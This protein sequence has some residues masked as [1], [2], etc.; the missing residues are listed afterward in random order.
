MRTSISGT[1]SRISSIS[2]NSLV[3][4]RLAR[5]LTGVRSKKWQEMAD[6]RAV[7]AAAT[8][9]RSSQEV[10]TPTPA[11]ASS[12]QGKEEAKASTKEE[13]GGGKKQELQPVSQQHAKNKT[14]KVPPSLVSPARVDQ[15]K[16]MDK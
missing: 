6:A 1:S 11:A 16:I 3:M 10:Q 7:A 12:G 15:E 13:E 2:G 4:A 8:S 9:R 14:C 5:T